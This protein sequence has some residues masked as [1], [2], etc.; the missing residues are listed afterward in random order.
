MRLSVGTCVCVC[1]CVCVYV[2][3]FCKCVCKCECICVWVVWCGCNQLPLAECICVL[4]VHLWEYFSACTHTYIHFSVWEFVRWICVNLSPHVLTF[5]CTCT[6][7][8]EC[9]CTYVDLALGPVVVGAVDEL[10]I[11]VVEAEGTEDGEVEAENVTQ[12]RQ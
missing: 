11:I 10:N 7:M 12:H 5:E 3:C 9:T 6:Y 8:F 1:L 4:C 2:F